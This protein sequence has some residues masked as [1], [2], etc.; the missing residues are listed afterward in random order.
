MP[1]L[2]KTAIGTVTALW[3]VA[4]IKQPDG[5]LR[6]L[7]VGDA[8]RQGD[9]ILT[10]QEGIVQI[11]TLDGTTRV[12]RANTPLDR[13][14]EAVESGQEAPG[15]G[16]GGGDAGSMQE[17]FRVARISEPLSDLELRGALDVAAHRVGGS[18]MQA[19]GASSARADEEP[20]APPESE[21]EP[22]AEAPPQPQP[23]PEAGR[24]TGT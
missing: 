6:P 14:I 8:I 21:P 16:V 7:K 18:V 19:D 2:A 17:G 23:Q 1:T 20:Q 15:A 13:V 10:D 24:R 11:N 12:A 4:M 9:V 22:Q 3:G 5:T